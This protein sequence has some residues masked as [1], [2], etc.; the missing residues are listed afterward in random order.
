[1]GHSKIVLVFFTFHSCSR[2]WSPKPHLSPQRQQERR[3]L[4]VSWNTW[5][6]LPVSSSSLD[7]R[8]RWSFFIKNSC[9]LDVYSPHFYKLYELHSSTLFCCLDVPV[10]VHEH[11]FLNLQAEFLDV[12]QGLARRIPYV[13]DCTIA[14]SAQAGRTLSLFPLL[15]MSMYTHS[16]RY[17]F[18]AY[19][20]EEVNAPS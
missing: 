1:M 15:L 9:H 14:A 19:S 7:T 6:L 16:F 13:F 10:N 20:V 8:R 4:S 18:F 5:I 2:P 11:L 12:N 17:S 3:R